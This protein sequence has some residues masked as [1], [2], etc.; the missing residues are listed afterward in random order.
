MEWIQPGLDALTTGVEDLRSAWETLQPAI[1]PI[2][3]M[4]KYLAGIIGGLLVRMAAI[5]FNALSEHFAHLTELAKGFAEMVAWAAEKLAALVNIKLPDY[6][7]FFEGMS[8]HQNQYS[9][10]SD[11]GDDGGR[12]GSWTS[13]TQNNEV[14]VDSPEAAA[15]YVNDA[16]FD[17]YTFAN[18]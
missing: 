15:E 2:I 10:L 6:S 5:M 9:R 13:I 11:V 7:S 1:A 4:L 8:V 14:H 12:G 16:G 3:G 18:S 17:S